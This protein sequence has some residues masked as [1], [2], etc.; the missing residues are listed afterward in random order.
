M[1]LSLSL[2]PA[3]AEFVA[4]TTTPNLLLCGGFGSGK[5]Y[6]GALKAIILALANPGTSG[7]VASPTLGL[8]KRSIVKSLQDALVEHRIKHTYNKS[9]LIFRLDVG[10]GRASEIYIL[11]AENWTRLIGM[12]ASFFVFDEMD[13][14]KADDA[15]E[16]WTKLTSRVRAGKV[17]QMCAT[18]TPEGFKFAYQFFQQEVAEKPE[19]ATQRKIIRART[20]DNPY[21]PDEY[22][23]ALRDAYPKDLL[24]AYLEGEFVNF[25]SGT[26]YCNYSRAL[27]DTTLTIYDLP[28]TRPLIVGVDFNYNGMSAIVAGQFG[29][30][31][32]DEYGRRHEGSD[33]VTA[34]VDEIIG[35]KNTT[36]L[37]AALK[38]RY[39]DRHLIICP[40][41]S[42]GHNSSKSAGATDFSLLAQ[43]GF[44]LRYNPSN[45]RIKDRVNSVNARLLNGTGQRRLKVNATR[46]PTLARCL[47]QQVYGEDGMPRK[48]EKISSNS[49]T[50]MDGPLDG[51]GY[52]VWQFFPLASRP[53]MKV[54]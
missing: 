31:K 44:Q 2:L 52:L 15:R 41:A 3:Q 21:L 13:T 48:G 34:V 45:P 51:L 50:Y 33:V 8:A 46:C 30:P 32:F 36:E 12:N 10:H 54:S 29:E 6:A 22:I 23:R 1:H 39:G 4:D 5:S 20:V 38:E 28:S 17:R 53:T 37:I 47:E 40:D 11:S 18:T 7:I 24:R 42:G 19:L 25:R 27:N 9:E 14:L 43:A 35:S 16:A 49:E 26:V